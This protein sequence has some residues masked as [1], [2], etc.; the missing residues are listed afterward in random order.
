[1]NENEIKGA[2]DTGVGK[3]ESF[4]GR[5]AG[6]S[7]LKAGGAIDETKGKVQALAGKVQEAVGQTADQ[8]TETLAK[9]SEQTKDAYSRASQSAQKL[10]GA[11]DPFVQERPYAAVVA[12]AGI[13]L[14]L[15][16]LLAGR[17]PRVIYVGDFD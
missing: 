7:G 3:A 11:V 16:L 8:A 13:G 6:A 5:A 2:I 10:A 17:G 1:M 15:G 14:I 4:A 12:A 9:I